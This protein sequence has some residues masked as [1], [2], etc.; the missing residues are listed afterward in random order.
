MQIDLPSPDI[1]FAKEVEITQNF[2][3]DKQVRSAY[4]DVC[5]H[6]SLLWSELIARH[7]R[8]TWI[9]IGVSF[10][11]LANDVHQDEEQYRRDLQDLVAR[12]VYDEKMLNR[13]KQCTQHIYVRLRE[14]WRS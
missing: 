7:I 5:S 12:T 11:V 9:G 3:K 14:K 4:F 13:I 6:R 1:V 2:W 8:K 10:I